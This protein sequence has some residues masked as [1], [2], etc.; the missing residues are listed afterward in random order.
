VSAH[1]EIV[2]EPGAAV[3][4]KLTVGIGSRGFRLLLIAWST[5]MVGDGV[6]V[7]ALPLFAAVS[8]RDPLVV[9]AVAVAEVLPW[10]LIALPAGG[11]VDRWEPRWVVLS[12]HGVRAVVILLLATS[13][14]TGSA[15]VGLLVAAAF[16]V[17]AAETFADPASQ[18]LLVHLAGPHGLEKGNGYFVSVETMAVDIVGPWPRGCSSFGNLQRASHST[19]FRSCSLGSSSPVCRDPCRPHR[20]A[21][22]TTR[23]VD[24]SVDWPPR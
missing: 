19:A 22:A 11:L 2:P 3:R 24:R 20:L 1:F 10:L 5:S 6:R 8:T 17:T 15:G 4:A 16:V 18:R 14:A 7:A 23:S 21:W 9:S 13:V 12:A